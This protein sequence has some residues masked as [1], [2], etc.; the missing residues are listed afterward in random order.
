MKGKKKGRQK[1]GNV[2]DAR[3]IL[4]LKISNMMLADDNEIRVLSLS[5]ATSSVAT[6]ED[7]CRGCIRRQIGRAKTARELVYTTG[8]PTV[9]NLKSVRRI[10]FAIA[11]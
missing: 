1:I 8:K 10:Q 7:N 6:V 9:P 3:Q 11:Q 5:L 4:P 2:C